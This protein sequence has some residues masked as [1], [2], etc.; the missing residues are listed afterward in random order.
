M[1]NA[2]APFHRKPAGQVL[3]AT[4][5]FCFIF[6]V[7][8][9][10]LCRS[11]AA[12]IYKERSRRAADLTALS[13]GA[14]YA[15]GLEWVRLT[16]MVDVALAAV[17]I[18]TIFWR[19]SPELALL[20]ESLP[21]IIP[22]A[23][24]ADP[25][26]RVKIGQKLQKYLFGIGIPTGAFPMLMKAVVPQVASANG[27][28]APLFSPLQFYNF[29]T[30]TLADVAVPNMALTF[31][32]AADLLPQ[33]SQGTYS[34][35]HDGLRVYFSP[36]Q[37]ESAGNPRHPGQMRVRSDLPSPYAGWW[38]RKES[39]GEGDGPLGP[40][41][42]FGGLKTLQ[43]LRDFLKKFVLDVTDRDDPPCHTFTLVGG[44]PATLAGK[45][46]TFY[47]VS[48]VR[49]EADG[50]AAWDVGRPILTHLQSPDLAD[51]PLFR[52]FPLLQN[53][54]EVF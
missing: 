31:R 5:L 39:A 4:L 8:F 25:K 32:T 51:F 30:A 22:A 28:S 44:Y 3:L 34:L 43:L 16:N 12:F 21:T 23:E 54:S 38:V 48:E 7:L 14:V 26:T 52:K 27:L 49:V 35:E 13:I 11:G 37:V 6:A 53:F 17:D 9:L 1:N 19:I 36:S 50:L 18:G 45:K 47:Q 24:A 20:P 29:E 46:R 40:L 2:L 42:R 33:P 41:S 15:D 10:G